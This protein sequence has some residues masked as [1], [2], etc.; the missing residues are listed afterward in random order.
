MTQIPQDWRIEFMGAHPR[1]FDFMQDEPKDTFGY[2]LCS[3]GWRDVLERLCGRI[4]EA[5]LDN[6]TF[7]F[8]RIKQK[9]GILRVGWE[10]RVSEETRARIEEALALAQA[11]SS[12][13]C[14]R[15]GAEGA[16]HHAYDNLLVRCEKHAEGRPML[17]TGANDRL[18]IVRVVGPTEPPVCILRRYD[19][20]TDSFVGPPEDW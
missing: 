3:E 17:A 7:G 11:R 5:L 12:C 16:K 8:V 4:E 14:E 2:P 13:T 10:G 6:E 19:R 20:V 18:H 9:F 1:L 15:C